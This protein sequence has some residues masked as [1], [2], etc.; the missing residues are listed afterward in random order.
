MPFEAREIDPAGSSRAQLGAEIRRLRTERGLSQAG[1]G[2]LIHCSADLVR[3]VET[4]ERFPTQDFLVACDRAL[5]AGGL[6]TA[7]WPALSA[8]RRRGG[9]T[10]GAAVRLVAAESDMAVSAWLAGSGAGAGAVSESPS[11]DGD[12]LWVTE[13]DLAV[14]EGMLTMFRQLDHA[15]GPG[16]FAPQLVAYTE[17]ELALLLSRQAAH[18]AVA[19][20]LARLASRFWELAGYQAV[21]AGQP[22]TAQRYYQ[23]ALQLADEA[24]DRCLGGYLVAVNLGHLALHCEHPHIAMRWAQAAETAVGTAASPSTRAAILAVQARAQARMGRESDSTGL[25]LRAEALVSSAEGVEEPEWIRY[26]TR[27]YLADEIAHCLHDLGRPSDTRVEAADALNGVGITHVRRLAIDTALVATSW[28]RSEDV[29]QACAVARDA[30]GYAARTSS[31]RCVQ[32]IAVL[33]TELAPHARL[34]CV[35]DLYAY[36]E[37]VLS[38][39]LL[40]QP[41]TG[42]ASAARS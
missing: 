32:R 36:V 15:H 12:G 39:A 9:A 28:L 7:L 6:L 22:G 40:A 18:P 13:Q 31:G 33:L 3:R 23:R 42:D 37:Q 35:A 2:R 5:D 16:T 20:E 14:A 25:L 24:E 1:L 8:E 10:T 34:A 26:F 30:V 19:C 29:E 21:D 41:V 17:R 38:A 4:T 27:A 11:R